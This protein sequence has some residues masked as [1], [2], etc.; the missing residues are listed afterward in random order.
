MLLQDKVVIVTGAARGIGKVY[1]KGIAE[2]GGKVAVS[3]ILDGEETVEEIRKAGGEATYVRADVSDEKSV[4]ALAEAVHSRFGRIDGLVN[5]AA[6]FAD[7][8]YCPFDEITVEEWDAVMAV[9]VKGVWLASKA[10]YPYMKAQGSGKIVNIAS[11]T[12]FKGNPNF[13]HYTVS[14]GAVLTLTR[15]L[16]RSMGKDGICVNCIGPGLT[17]SESLQA[18]RGAELDEEEAHMLHTRA[19]PRS[20]TPDDLVGAI[21]FF[22]SGGADFIAGQTLMVD[23]GSYM[24]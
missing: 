13:A 22:L 21:V 23:G 17:R 5:N 10:V 2:A 18:A 8:R 19:L 4:E 7:V 9:N 1:A 12:P 6:I 16:A 3:D 11:G 20:E 15:V 24:K 14:K